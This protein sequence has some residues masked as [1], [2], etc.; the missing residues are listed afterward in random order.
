D[1]RPRSAPKAAGVGRRETRASI[2]T[3]SD[4]SQGS[5]PGGKCTKPGPADGSW[6][7]PR[8]LNWAFA[9][10]SERPGSDFS[11]G[12]SLMYKFRPVRV[13]PVIGKC[14]Y[15]CLTDRGLAVHGVP[16]SAALGDPGGDNVDVELGKPPDVR[17][18]RRP[19]DQERGGAVEAPTR[20][21]QGS[22]TYVDS[23]GS[24]SISWIK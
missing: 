9:G 20:S 13:M 6:D 14:T 12:G 24:P 4:R 21:V 5:D 18:G 3:F 19:G 11:S 10:K 17:F 8:T 1:L 2:C 22:T 23:T 16:G 7:R 15:R